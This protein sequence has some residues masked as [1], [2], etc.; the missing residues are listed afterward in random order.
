MGEAFPV[1]RI[2]IN[3]LAKFRRTMQMQRGRLE[4]EA[5]RLPNSDIHRA[6]CESGADTTLEFVVAPR[7]LC[8]FRRTIISGNAKSAAPAE[9][10][11]CRKPLF[12]KDFRRILARAFRK[13]SRL[14]QSG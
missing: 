11:V 4:E 10:L 3:G 7:V 13:S 2:V 5:G 6:S 8:D 9:H 14:L 1:H 12:D